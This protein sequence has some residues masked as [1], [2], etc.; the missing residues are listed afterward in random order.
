MW[1]ISHVIPAQAAIHGCMNSAILEKWMPAGV[2]PPAAL[3]ADR[4][5][6]MTIL[7]IVEKSGINAKKPGASRAFS[8]A[9][10]RYYL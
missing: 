6:G 3:C 9:T 8:S 5:T 4:G 2:Y 10:G 1:Q 7:V